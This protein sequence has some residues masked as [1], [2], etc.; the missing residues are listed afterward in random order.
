MTNTSN[1]DWPMYLSG[2][3]IMPEYINAVM[4]RMAIYGMYKGIE[5]LHPI[6]SVL[7]VNL[8]TGLCQTVFNLLV[9]NFVRTDLFIRIA[10]ATN[11]CYLTFHCTAW[12]V[13]SILRYVFIMHK[14]WIES[15][16]E[17][18]KTLSSISVLG[19][20][21]WNASLIVPVVAYT[22]H[23][24]KLIL[25][26]AC[27]QNW[28]RLGIRTKRQCMQ[29]QIRFRLKD[30]GLIVKKLT[31]VFLHKGSVSWCIKII[32]VGIIIKSTSIHPCISVQWGTA[33]LKMYVGWLGSRHR[34]NKF[35]TVNL[36]F[37]TQKRRDE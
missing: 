36:I 32:K 2:A 35:Q 11:C 18:L 29:S 23:L 26:W 22:I 8:I 31:V 17:N 21:I 3:M 1:T 24:G 10:N 15:K 27:L 34:P 5:I 14:D 19:V 33:E 25:T 9:F 30:F 16:F 4:L 37:I 6:Y 13:T 20:M 12:S 7:F 28:Y